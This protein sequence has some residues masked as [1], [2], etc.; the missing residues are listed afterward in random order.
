MSKNVAILGLG[1]LGESLAVALNNK[2]FSI[3]G[4]T[5]SNAQLKQLTR[6]PFYV[7][8]I[9]LQP[10]EILGDWN[11]FINETDYLIINIP[12]K[13]IEN[14]K[15]VFP[16]QIQ[17]LINRTP[18]DVKVIFVSSTAVYGNSKK[19]LTEDDNTPPNKSSGK[20]LITAENLLKAHFRSNLT[21]LRLAGLIGPNR[22][23]GNFLSEKRTLRSP[24][25][26]VNLI[27]R[28]DCIAL[29][30][31]IIKKDCFGHVINGCS[32]KHPVREQFY[33]NAANKLSL[34]E[35]NFDKSPNTSDYKIV[36]NTKS[37]QLLDFTYQYDDPEDIFEQFHKTKIYVVGAG[38][39]NKELLTLQAF[40]LITS[41]EII[42]HDNLVSDEVLNINTSAEMVYVGRKYGDKGGQIERQANINQLLVKYHQLGKRVV[43]L[44][45]GDPYIYGR[46]AEEAIY[47]TQNNI[48]FEVIPGISAALAAANSC[49]IP[50]TE[51]NKSN[52]VLIC[53]A[54]TADYSF[55]QLQGVA[56]LLKAGN[57]LALYMG[58]KSLDKLIPKLIE[59][60]QN[61]DIPIN[62]ISNVSRENEV[63]LTSTLGE[64]IEDIKKSLIEMPVV[65]L[66]GIKPIQ[67]I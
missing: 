20:A 45:S 54:H 32:S 25:V 65:F 62:A 56:A 51:R 49:N 6:H 10:Y 37:K 19:P 64:I 43:R 21:I 7:G 18:K 34:E 57:T 24:N 36:D 28:E 33:N 52:A 67:K 29:I 1:W 17:Q 27:H 40:E 30:E 8:K 22:H 59:T 26:P 35:P 55:D 16:Q 48:P 66:I 2:G 31:N 14:I 60:C 50:I 3:S 58:M 5:T 13:R 12:P 38:P 46:A 9:E 15:E 53:T 44:K 42:L 4:S 11:T 41:A 61:P 23:P 39:G 47:L 63:L